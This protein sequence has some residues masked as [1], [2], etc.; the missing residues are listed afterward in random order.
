MTPLPAALGGES[1]VAWRLDRAKHASSWD[2]GEGAFQAGGRWN[3]RGFRAV[4]ACLDPAT[5][6]LEVAVHKGFA[7]L[8]AQPHVLTRF[9]IATPE[10]V[11]VIGPG[12]IPNP[13][14]LDPNDQTP[15]KR[16]WGAET[17]AR[18]KMIV[19]P[20]AV[21]RRSW[22]LVFQAPLSPDWF[23]KSEQEDFVL[24]PRLHRKDV[25]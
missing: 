3:P 16:A 4:Y 12:D 8:D 7:V 18:H 15:D 5:A 14:W 10:R 6:I 25:L 1:L 9:E 13:E 24:N 22:N 21:S 23:G 17:I 11:A 2:G 19:L 20:S